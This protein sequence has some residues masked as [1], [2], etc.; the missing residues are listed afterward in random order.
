M[1]FLSLINVESKTVSLLG[2]T[3]T[4]AVPLFD[5]GNLGIWTLLFQIFLFL[6]LVFICP[7]SLPQ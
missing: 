5:H 6:F 7:V 1:V 2:A 4:V 3:P